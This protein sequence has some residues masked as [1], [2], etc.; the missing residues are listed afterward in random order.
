MVTDLGTDDPGICTIL[1]NREGLVLES[2]HD[3]SMLQ[4]GSYPRHLK[5]RIS[6]DRGH[7]SNQ[8][9]RDILEKVVGERTRNIVLA[10]LS[11]ENNDPLLAIEMSMQ[12][13]DNTPSGP[14]IH[15]SYPRHPTMLI[16][17]ER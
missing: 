3:P 5:R 16:D 2:N 6:D 10:H 17:L 14:D 9:C 13:F 4:R 8:Q 1:S 12:A 7:L 11:Q 15:V